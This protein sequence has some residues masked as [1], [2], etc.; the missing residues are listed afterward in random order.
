MAN[1]A[2]VT[3]HTSPEVKT[4][5]DRLATVTRRSK[6]FLANE[7]VERYWADEEAFV[8]NVEVGLA[9]ANAGLFIEH[10]RA[11]AYLRSLGTADPLP[12]LKP[13]RA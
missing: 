13:I 9:Q 2:T 7:A 1:R 6:S 8:A 12:M 10:D 11:V 5:L 4:R 3:F